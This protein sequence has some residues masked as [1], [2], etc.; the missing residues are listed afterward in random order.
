MLID[1]AFFSLFFLGRCEFVSFERKFRRLD[2]TRFFLAKIIQMTPQTLAFLSVFLRKKEKTN[3][4]Y[5]RGFISNRA[6]KI[7]NGDLYREMKTND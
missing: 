5:Y 7:D 1:I 4:I 2:N 6:A 3:E